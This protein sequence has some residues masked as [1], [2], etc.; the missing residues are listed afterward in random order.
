MESPQ[1]LPFVW[2]NASLDHGPPQHGYAWV[3]AHSRGRREYMQDAVVFCR[4]LA[5]H[6]PHVALAAVFDG[7]GPDG[8]NAARTAARFLEE[9]LRRPPAREAS[10]QEKLTDAFLYD[11]F[12]AVDERLR[13]ESYWTLSRSGTTCAAALITPD[14]LV[15]ASCGDSRALL[16]LARPAASP[17]TAAAVAATPDAETGVTAYALTAD[18]TPVDPGEAHR[19]EEQGGYV[20]NGRVLGQLAVSRCFGDFAFKD[21]N[22]VIVKPTIRRFPGPLRDDDLLALFSDGFYEG[23]RCGGGAVATHT[24]DLA[25]QTKTCQQRLAAVAATPAVGAPGLFARRAAAAVAGVVRDGSSDNVA[26]L[27]VRKAGGAPAGRGREPQT[28]AP[29]PRVAPRVLGSLA[30]PANLEHLVLEEAPDVYSPLFR[31]VVEYEGAYLRP[32]LQ[33]VEDHGFLLF[34]VSG[35]TKQVTTF[36]AATE[37]VLRRWLQTHAKQLGPARPSTPTAWLALTSAL[38]TVVPVPVRWETPSAA[39]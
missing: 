4:T 38:G 21:G 11:A 13:K 16:L 20:A 24:D 25:S 7:H 2:L 5:P 23:T 19:I 1:R 6:L 12:D 14:E 30:L 33:D 10:R 32:L 3:E 37:K 18:H 27:V 31:R 17:R 9:E 28:T 29:W 36:P 39:V 26:L 8:E 35:T 22:G 15:V 34:G